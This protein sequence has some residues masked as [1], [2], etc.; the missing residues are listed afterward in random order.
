MYKECIVLAG[1][2]GSRLQPVVSDVPKC[3]APVQQKPFLYYLCNWLGRQ[4]VSRVIFSLGYKSELV[5][6]YLDTCREQFPLEIVFSVEEEPLGTGGAILLAM[7]HVLGD[8]VLIINGDTF[9]D[10][11]LDDFVQFHRNG[12]AD[13]S[14]ALKPKAEADRYGL[15]HLNEQ[16]QVIRFSEKEKG[17]A[18]LINGG[19]YCMFKNSFLSIPFP[20]A[21][22]FEKD[23]LQAMVTERE[24]LGYVSDAYFLDIGIPEDYERAQREIPVHAENNDHVD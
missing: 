23:F 16:H 13:C 17:S 15:V 6:A 20:K 5:T 22:S 24:M 9:F 18:G 7:Q 12:M 14:I 21:F 1:G 8:D 11:P 3:L 19:I 10:I 4:K 2:L